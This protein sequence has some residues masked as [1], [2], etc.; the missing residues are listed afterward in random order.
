[1]HTFLAR[2]AIVT[3][4]FG[5][6]STLASTALAAAPSNDV[7]TG[8]TLVTLGFS[9][10]RDTS[11]ATTDA[12]DAELLQTCDAPAAN[13]SVWYALDG[14]GSRVLVDTS[15]SDYTTGLIVVAGSPGNFTPVTCGASAVAFDTEVGVRYAVLVFDLEG[16]GSNG[17][18]LTIA[19]RESL[20]PE[21]VF[22]VDRDG[23]IDPRCRDAT[24][25]GSYTCTAGTDFSIFVNASQ[26]DGRST[27]AGSGEFLGR[28][29]GTLQ[30]WSVV[31]AAEQGM[32]TTGKLNTTSF[33]VASTIDQGVGYEITQKVKLRGA[34]T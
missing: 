8:S 13:A 33:G 14:T 9:E 16:D 11:E 25:T 30:R 15:A 21:L 26:R 24:L 32:F 2:L 28:C 31:V 27:V 5:A 3:L 17:G 23:S 20:Q 4:L 18:M 7:F 19:V 1:M 12:T 29:D 22:D 6:L 34:R 10:T